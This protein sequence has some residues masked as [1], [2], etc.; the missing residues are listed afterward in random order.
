MNSPVD[1]KAVLDAMGADE[2][3]RS[4]PVRV[5]V[6]IDASAPEDLAN[7][8]AAATRTTVDT[9]SVV[10]DGYP[11]KH[12]L[13]DASSDLAVL[14][15]GA[16]GEAG[17]LYESLHTLGVPT[18]AFALDREGLRAA[19]REAGHPIAIDDII[20]PDGAGVDGESISADEAHAMLDRFGAWIVDVFSEKRLAFAYAFPCVR[21]PLAL[22]AVKST[23]VQNAGIG[24]VFIIPGAD[25]PLMTLNQVKMLLEMAAAYGEELSLGRV[26]EIAAIVGGAFAC[27]AVARQLAG[28]VPGVGWLVKGG[29]GYA[30]TIGMGYAL[31]N[32]FES[33]T[34]VVA[35]VQLAAGKVK[36][37]TEQAGVSPQQGVA[38]NAAIVAGAVLDRA[39]QTV[40]RVGGNLAPAAAAVAS[41]AREATG[42]SQAE[43]AEFADRA[44]GGVRRRLGR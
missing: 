18:V 19:A 3:A 42:F 25:L 2:E 30:G 7:I 15:A 38:A 40:G 9:A 31:L 44:V 14:V 22:E 24:V 29:I 17:G 35:S 11:P 1:I 36:D 28:A 39:A 27:R 37:A 6:Y 41:A 12:A 34:D 16:S 4:K 13:P 8:A 5:H 20:A 43:V 32:Y 33:G 21:R 10:Y 23:A 26:K